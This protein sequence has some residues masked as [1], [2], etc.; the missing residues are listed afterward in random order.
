MIPS[1]GTIGALGVI[2]VVG[3][4]G[5]PVAAPGYVCV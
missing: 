5:D 1:T 2:T 4:M 3:P